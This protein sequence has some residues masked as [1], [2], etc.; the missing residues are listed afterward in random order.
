MLSQ[1]PRRAGE[2]RW[3]SV[4]HQLIEDDVAH[5][6][7]VVAQV[8]LVEHARAVGAHRLD[9]EV[10]VIGDLREGDQVVGP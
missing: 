5:D 2:E 7:G 4:F 6:L 9:A 3:S 8:H 1:I 10:E